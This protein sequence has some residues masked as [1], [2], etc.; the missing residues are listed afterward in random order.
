MEVVFLQW[1]HIGPMG[2]IQSQLQWRLFLEIFGNRH[3]T[4]F[5]I[6]SPPNKMIDLPC[7]PQDGGDWIAVG[8]FNSHS[9]SWGYRNLNGKGEEVEDWIVTNRLVLINRPDD[10]PSFYSRVWHTTSSPDLAVATD[11]IQKITE[12]QVCAQLG[13][14]DPLSLQFR[15]M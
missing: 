3:L 14:S 2:P 7:L 8:D 10:L 11:G 5:N 1:R 4:V 6:Y 9:P 13:D 15:D 12:R